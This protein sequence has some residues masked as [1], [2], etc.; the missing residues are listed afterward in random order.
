MNSEISDLR[1]HAHKIAKSGK[2]A[3][4]VWAELKSWASVK[5]PLA[6]KAAIMEFVHTYHG[7]SEIVAL[8][9]ELMASTTLTP[10]EQDRI[11]RFTEQKF[12]RPSV[13]FIPKVSPP[14]LAL[15]LNPRT[16]SSLVYTELNQDPRQNIFIMKEQSR[17]M[18]MRPKAFEGRWD[19]V[20]REEI[21]TYSMALD[22]KRTHGEK[23]V[24]HLVEHI[25]SHGAS[26]VKQVT[27]ARKKTHTKKKTL[28]K[29]R[30]R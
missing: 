2:P 28:K 18:L 7:S 9:P 22:K 26:H 5:G 15:Q 17:A 4:M 6:M 29:S 21:Q 12:E 20:P 19:G 25:R 10:K 11:L 13:D 23:L 8:M 30:K 14:V 3:R 1:K 24:T 27:K 16:R